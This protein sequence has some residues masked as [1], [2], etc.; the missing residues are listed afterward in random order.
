M[1]PK[2]FNRSDTAFCTVVRAAGYHTVDEAEQ[3]VLHCIDGGDDWWNKLKGSAKI[4]PSSEADGWLDAR[5][6]SALTA[7]PTAVR[8][9]CR[10]VGEIT[11]EFMWTSEPRATQTRRTVRNMSLE[12]GW[13]GEDE[14]DEWMM[15]TKKI[16]WAFIA[17]DERGRGYRRRSV[18]RIS[19][20]ICQSIL[21][22]VY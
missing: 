3:I 20:I 22:C 19:V 13:T 12:L 14:D 6:W 7:L 17:S 16:D 11:A 1:A 8:V 21:C 5:W 2:A 4:L 18:K 15:K 10:A 9:F